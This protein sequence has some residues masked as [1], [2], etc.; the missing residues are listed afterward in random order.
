MLVST[1][2]RGGRNMCRVLLFEKSIGV[3]VIHVQTRRKEEGV[4]Y[5]FALEIEIDKY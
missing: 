1:F 5:I 3:P 4:M 2:S